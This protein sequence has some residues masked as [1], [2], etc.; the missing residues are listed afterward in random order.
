MLECKPTDLALLDQYQRIVL[1]QIQFDEDGQHIQGYDPEVYMYL[2]FREEIEETFGEDRHNP[3]YRRLGA[4]LSIP[5][6]EGGNVKTIPGDASPQAV[7]FHLKEFGDVSWYLANFL[8]IYGISMSEA[9]TQGEI[10][11]DHDNQTSPKCDAEFS[12]QT[13][14]VF[15]LLKYAGYMHELTGAFENVL[16]S[17]TDET[18]AKLQPSAGKFVLSMAHILGSR[19]GASYEEILAGNIAKIEKRIAD[20]TVFDKS[21][22][23]AR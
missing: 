13:E 14:R 11:W 23:D 4:L 19:L 17:A 3:G 12:V 7:D 20:G 1:S 2:G 6:P 10:A 5:L 8:N 16:R 15:P 22:G 18:V 9:V 21:G